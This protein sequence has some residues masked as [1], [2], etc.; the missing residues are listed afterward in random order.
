V[1]SAEQPFACSKCPIRFKFSWGLRRHE[2]A[3]HLG[4][5]PFVCSVCDKAFAEIGNLRTHVRTHTGERPFACCVCDQRFTQSSSLKTHMRLHR[6][7]SSASTESSSEPVSYLHTAP[8]ASPS[9]VLIQPVVSN[10][11][12]SESSVSLNESHSAKATVLAD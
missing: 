12:R 10:L 9:P 1:H 4:E 3:M 2:R 8:V 7:G 6:L 5:K 11:L